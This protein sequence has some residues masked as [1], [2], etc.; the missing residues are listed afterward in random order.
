[1]GTSSAVPLPPLKSLT[2]PMGIVTSSIVFPTD[3]TVASSLA[4]LPGA[5]PRVRKAVLGPVGYT[6]H[7]WKKVLVLY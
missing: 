4:G 6:T 2:H 1:M 5:I 7:L 3:F